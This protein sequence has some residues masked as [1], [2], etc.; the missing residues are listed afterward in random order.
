MLSAPKSVSLMA[1]VGDDRRVTA[2]HDRA[3]TRTLV[4][5]ENNVVETRLK[6]RR[7]GR[8]VRTGGHNM[9][10]APFRHDTSRNLDPQLHTHAVI[11]NMVRGGDGKWRTMANEKLYAS[12]MLVG[13]LCRSELAQGLAGSVTASRR[14]TPTGVSRSPGFHAR[15]S[16][17][18]WRS[19]A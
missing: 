8:M 13:A 18:R 1:L 17:R 12:K 2:A 14:L 16:R 9:V 3:V 19:A 6:D 4:W 11:A 5:V 10:A 7:T 15:R